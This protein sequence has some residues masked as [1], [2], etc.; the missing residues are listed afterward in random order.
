MPLALWAN[1]FYLLMRTMIAGAPWREHFPSRREEIAARPFVL[2]RGLTQFL[3][4]TSL[5]HGVYVMR[6]M[7]LPIIRRPYCRISW[8]ICR[9]C[10][11]HRTCLPTSFPRFGFK[12]LFILVRLLLEYRHQNLPRAIPHCRRP[13]LE[14]PWV[15]IP[16]CINHNLRT[17]PDLSSAGT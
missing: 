4:L 17:T 13:F 11:T 6:I 2:E 12:W 5:V 10:P 7:K 16:D 14:T 1:Q 8:E 15:A 9:P 3:S